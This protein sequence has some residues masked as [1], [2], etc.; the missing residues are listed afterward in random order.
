MGLTQ[1][2]FL[3]TDEE[4]RK[5]TRYFSERAAS[6]A[7][8]REDAPQSVSVSFNFH[9]G[10]GRTVVAKVDG[11]SEGQTI[12]DEYED[13]MPETAEGDVPSGADYK[14]GK[15]QLAKHGLFMSEDVQGGAETDALAHSFANLISSM[16]EGKSDKDKG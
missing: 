3:L 13:Q 7:Q 8:V 1:S 2:D 4:L 15:Q 10:F 11:E 14:S 12:S 6:Y 9:V 16:Q 5:I